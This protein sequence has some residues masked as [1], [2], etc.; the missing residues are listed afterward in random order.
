MDAH[1]AFTALAGV[2]GI[3]SLKDL[4][5]RILAIGDENTGKS[6]TLNRLFEEEFFPYRGKNKSVDEFSAKTRRPIL[7]SSCPIE[8]DKYLLEH[9]SG[10]FWEGSSKSEALRQIHEKVDTNQ[11]PGISGEEMQFR[12]S[13]PGLQP[14]TFI[15]LPGLR[16]DRPEISEMVRSYVQNIPNQLG[17]YFMLP[18]SGFAT[19]LASSLAQNSDRTRSALIFVRPDSLGPEDALWEKIFAKPE[20]NGFPMTSIFV[21]R[22]PDTSVEESISFDKA[23]QQEQEF[24]ATH[25]VLSRMTAHKSQFGIVNLYKFI[26]KKIV[27][28]VVKALPD[29]RFHLSETLRQSEWEYKKLNT[30]VTEKNASNIYQRI[31][32]EYLSSISNLL[33]GKRGASEIKPFLKEQLELSLREI[34]VSAALKEEIE[35]SQRAYGGINMELSGWNNKTWIDVLY[36]P[37]GPV[38]E[39]RT[40]VRYN[41]EFLHSRFLELFRVKLDVNIDET[42]WDAFHSKELATMLPSGRINRAVDAAEAYLKLIKL[43]LVN[44]FSGIFRALYIDRNV[45]AI[46]EMLMNTEDLI[47]FIKE[48]ENAKN[49]RI[50]LEDEIKRYRHVLNVLS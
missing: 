31:V 18:I 8:R 41:I 40:K 9:S 29:I 50:H 12:I 33:E 46:T 34:E 37:H 36:R 13:G 43:E 15:D 42:F 22:N 7:I 10:S 23:I 30:V 48:P 11:G 35:A 2:S 25:P 28:G 19:T 24:F 20:Y 21:I 38:D 1:K 4:L 3:D 17:L 45:E 5:I 26:Q 27:E 47:A 39:I 6:I 14:I 16:T 49:R 32:Y 44:D